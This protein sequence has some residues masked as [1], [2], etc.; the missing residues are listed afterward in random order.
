MVMDVRLEALALTHASALLTFELANRAFFAAHIADRGDDYFE[1][2][3]DRLTALVAEREART[4]LPFVLLDST[5]RIIGRVN[6]TDIDRPGDTELGFRVAQAVQGRGV[7]TLGVRLALHQA[8]S[9]GVA[10]VQARASI[11]N[12]PSQRVL[13][14]CGFTSTGPTAAPPGSSQAFIGFAK[15]LRD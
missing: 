10:R 3:G 6:I 2:F 7:A 5:E 1:H 11:D 9:A 13:T 8:A 15:D 14:R 12:I 4:S